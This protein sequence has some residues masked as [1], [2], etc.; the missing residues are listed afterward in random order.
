VSKAES[1]PLPPPDIYP[2]KSSYFVTFNHTLLCTTTHIH[3]TSYR[4][5]DLTLSP[6]FGKEA[7]CKVLAKESALHSIPGIGDSYTEIPV[8]I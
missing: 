3:M 6:L 5:T 8:G 2:T 1:S 4:S 7:R